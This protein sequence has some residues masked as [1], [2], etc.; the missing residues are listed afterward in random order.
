MHAY[1]YTDTACSEGKRRLLPGQCVNGLSDKGWR[2]II[3]TESNTLELRQ[4]EEEERIIPRE[5]EEEEERGHRR[6][7]RRRTSLNQAAANRNNSG[8]GDGATIDRCI[9]EAW[10]AVDF[11]TRHYA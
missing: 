1:L 7:S 6:A 11:K 5:E 4:E 10:I 8:P 9:D 2:S 3:I